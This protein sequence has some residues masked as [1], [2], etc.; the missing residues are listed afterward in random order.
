MAEKIQRSHCSCIWELCFF[1]ISHAKRHVRSIRRQCDG[2]FRDEETTLAITS[3][4]TR[5]GLV[6]RNK[7]QEHSSSL[8]QRWNHGVK[9][10]SLSPILDNTWQFCIQ[11]R[12]GKRSRKKLALQDRPVSSQM[13]VL[14]MNMKDIMNKTR[15]CWSQYAAIFFLVTG[16]SSKLQITQRDWDWRGVEQIMNGRFEQNIRHFRAAPK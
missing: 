10:G 8:S 2:S 9:D 7:T 5:T 13:S 3:L 12:L 14:R 15:I 11:I 16:G 1:L 4:V 6:Q